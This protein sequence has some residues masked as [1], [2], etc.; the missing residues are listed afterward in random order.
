[1]HPLNNDG[2]TFDVPLLEGDFVSTE[3]GTGF[4]HVAPGHGE[5]DFELGQ[6]FGIPVPDVVE[7]GGTYFS[8]VPLFAGVHVF[9]AL[10]PVC[11]ALK[12]NFSLYASEKYTHS[13]PHFWR[14]KKPIIYRATQQWFISMEK[15]DLKKIALESIEKTIWVPSISCLLYTSP[16]PRD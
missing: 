10:E 14:S 5:D 8:N 3:Q 15:N 4:V 11:D 2:Y 12:K 7:D 16:S 13:Y 6:K 9:K 1:M